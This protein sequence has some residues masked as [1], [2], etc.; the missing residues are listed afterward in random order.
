M[1]HALLTM[2]T[3]MDAFQVNASVPFQINDCINVFS[4]FFHYGRRSGGIGWK[5]ATSTLGLPWLSEVWIRGSH[6]S[7][8]RRYNK[9]K[10]C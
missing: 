10:I 4:D 5:P 9:F 6:F 3:L 1:T 7:R 2:I 8:S